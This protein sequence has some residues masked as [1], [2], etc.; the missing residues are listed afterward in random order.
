MLAVKYI[1][2]QFSHALL[3]SN[4]YRDLFLYHDFIHDYKDENICIA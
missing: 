4:N 3:I 2:R 1:T